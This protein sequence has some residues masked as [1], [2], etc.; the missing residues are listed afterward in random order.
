MIRL[1]PRPPPPSR[2]TAAAARRVPAM[3]AALAAHGG[4]VR[5]GD[6]ALDFAPDWSVAKP[7]LSAWQH[8]KCAF[9]EAR[10]TAHQHGDVEH[11]RPK[12]AVL[13]PT[14]E[15]ERPGYW[16]LAWEWTNL[17]FVCQICNQ[18]HKKNRFPLADPAARARGPSDG[19]DREAPLLLDP[20][21]DEPADHLAFH[22][23][24]VV[25]TTQRGRETHDVVGLSRPALEED[26]RHHLAVL[27]ALLELWSVAPPSPQ[28]LAAEQVLTDATHPAAPYAAMARALIP[29][30]LHA[31]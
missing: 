16:W 2:L 1:G 30:A 20:T 26:R 9:C 21:N 25:P 18:V 8:G 13:G 6:H 28:R 31:R 14:G 29:A 19:L 12:A 11:F 4:A 10:L 3:A 7:T 15:L 17:L 5:R 27:K 24:L 23:E 22:G